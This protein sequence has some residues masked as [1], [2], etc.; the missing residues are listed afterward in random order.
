[1]LDDTARAMIERAAP[2]PPLPRY[3]PRDGATITLVIPV[4]PPAP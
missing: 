1:V 2:F 4:F 3:Y